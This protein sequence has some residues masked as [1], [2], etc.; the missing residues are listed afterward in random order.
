MLTRAAISILYGH[1]SVL[2]SYRRRLIYFM[3]VSIEE[4]RAKIV[5]AIWYYKEELRERRK[6]TFRTLTDFLFTIWLEIFFLFIYL[7][8]W[9]VPIFIASM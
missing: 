3:I 6:T 2:L 8:N 4:G 1:I 9:I 5:S 7:F